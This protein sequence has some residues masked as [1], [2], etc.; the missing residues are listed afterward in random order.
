MV[1]GTSTGKST[2]H[3]PLGNIY[4]PKKMSL[5]TCF[6]L[7]YCISLSAHHSSHQLIY[8]SFQNQFRAKLW[9]LPIHLLP[10]CH[11]Q[12]RENSISSASTLKQEQSVFLLWK[13]QRCW[14][15]RERAGREKILGSA[16]PPCAAVFQKGPA[17]RF[18]S[19]KLAFF[20]RWIPSIPAEPEPA[21]LI[22]AGNGKSVEQG[23][24]CPGRN[25][26]SGFGCCSTSP[27]GTDISGGGG[28]RYHLRKSRKN[29]PGMC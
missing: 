1:V 23:W 26:E 18:R 21:R 20:P 16:E 11:A 13:Q 28:Q 29:V 10:L 7:N 6:T 5:Q 14:E 3:S 22:R 8:S 9:E 17:G 24:P 25:R 4:W 15:N 19:S 12:P 2:P 27:G